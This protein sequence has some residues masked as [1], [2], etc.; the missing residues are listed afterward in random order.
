MKSIVNNRTY[1]SLLLVLY[2]LFIPMLLRAASGS[3]STRGSRHSFMVNAH[4]NPVND[5]ENKAVLLFS[6]KSQAKASLYIELVD[7][8]EKTIRIDWGEGNGVEK[9]TLDENGYINHTFSKDVD[10]YHIVIIDVSNVEILKD[11]DYDGAPIGV[12]EINAPKMIAFSTSSALI[13]TPEIDF[14]HLPKLQYVSFNAVS[15]F[16]A[17]DSLLSFSMYRSTG[18]S[19]PYLT[20]IDLSRAKKLK[21]LQIQQASHML[22]E[23]DLTQNKELTTLMISGS[24]NLSMKPTL[25]TI[26]GVKELKNLTYCN[27]EYNALDF[28]NLISSQPNAASPYVFQ[29]D[30]QRFVIPKDKIGVSKV[31][32]SYLREISD[33]LMEGTHQSTYT[34]YLAPLTEYD[35][36]DE[37]IDPSYYEERDGVFTFKPGA[38]GTG[39][40]RAKIVCKVSNDAYPFY[41]N[42]YSAPV[43]VSLVDDNHCVYVSDGAYAAWVEPS[44]EVYVEKEED[45]QWI[46]EKKINIGDKVEPGTH[47]AVKVLWDY[48]MII[49]NWTINGDI[50][51][52]SAA[53]AKPFRGDMLRFI[54]PA[55]GAVEVVPNFTNIV[56]SWKIIAPDGVTD[57]ELS[58]FT[59]NVT[60]TQNGKSEIVLGQ[61]I[62]TLYGSDVGCADALFTFEASC[63]SG[64]KVDKWFVN[65]VK[66][67]STDAKLSYQT[68]LDI[69]SL[70]VEVKFQTMVSHYIVSL[71]S[72]PSNYAEET[73]LKGKAPN[74]AF[75]RLTTEWVPEGSIVRAYVKPA[76]L[77]KIDKFIVNGNEF[78]G[79]VVDAGV[80][81]Q[82]IELS[83]DKDTEIVAK[84][85]HQ[86]GTITFAPRG[87]NATS[88]GTELIVTKQ[89]QDEAGNWVDGEV[90]QSGDHLAPGQRV[91]VFAKYDRRFIIKNWIVND[92]VWTDSPTEDKVSYANPIFIRMPEE[93]DLN[94]VLELDRVNMVCFLT[95]P[96]GIS[97]GKEQFSLTVSLDGKLLRGQEMTPGVKA[98]Y[99]ED[100]EGKTIKCEAKAM[101]GYTPQWT[102]DGTKR[103]ERDFVIDVTAKKNLT[104]RLA[105]V[106]E[107]GVEHISHNVFVYGVNGQIGIVAPSQS[108]YSVYSVNGDLLAQGRIGESTSI[109]IPVIRGLY[110]VVVDGISYKVSVDIDK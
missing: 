25:T 23:I 49:D 100:L 91:K 26:K 3:S 29:Y 12:R 110:I 9:V 64:Y 16:I 88:A 42:S 56:V 97:D 18:A 80:E 65:G 47:V 48:G 37:R 85:L 1:K 69:H 2:M 55:E 13:A 5:I 107:K 71:S 94:V 17:P 45:G 74:G 82:Y 101:Q 66:Q 14:S 28:D 106:K 21:T 11:G 8:Q 35:P 30:F 93:G 40:T 34:W 50:V 77:C 6:P 78:Q 67:E 84:M 39:V 83:I 73:L 95:I 61:R 105:F 46:I 87:D 36:L 75:E 79:A 81:G 103:S 90:V 31:D 58:K 59:I 53:D 92:R 27:L 15:S 108:A 41:S 86:Y 98:Y 62:G 24:T 4:S 19:A 76:A 7:P 44:Y 72:D 38:F 10:G 68:T 60:K 57:E 54:M 104:I 89:M 33:G 70:K 99:V 102:V 96:D 20:S 22:K 63:P 52:V 109:Q 32:L 43:T 51:T